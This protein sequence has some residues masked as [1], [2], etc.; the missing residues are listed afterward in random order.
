MDDLTS[1][2]RARVP[3]L[4]SDLHNSA[5]L[6]VFYL[7]A[8]TFTLSHVFCRVTHKKTDD[9]DTEEFW[10]TSWLHWPKTRGIRSDQNYPI[11]T[12]WLKGP[13][14]S[15][16]SSLLSI[17]SCHTHV[18]LDQSCGSKRVPKMGTSIWRFFV[19]DRF[20][21]NIRPFPPNFFWVFF[22]YMPS[23]FTTKLWSLRS[24]LS[25]VHP[26]CGDMKRLWR[27]E[28]DYRTSWSRDIATQECQSHVMQYH[29][30]G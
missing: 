12:A 14:S 17:R 8:C 26:W 3:G 13:S 23:N 7:S 10:P 29:K 5:I 20:L 22:M 16:L 18:T 28:H 2:A 21:F 15:S 19:A 9:S 30:K 24:W 4:A 1:G 11:T 6:W 25:S 27:A